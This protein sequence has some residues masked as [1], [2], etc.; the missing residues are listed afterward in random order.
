M[1]RSTVIV[2]GILTLSTA[3]LLLGARSG[4][5]PGDLAALFKS[6]AIT[7]AEGIVVRELRLPR[8]LAALIAGAA[9]GMAGALIQTLTR[10]PIA[11]P[12]LLGVNAGAA[13]GIVT[14]VWI[15]GPI[16]QPAM[17]LPA[18][19]G[20]LLSLLVVWTIGASSRSPLTLIL[21]GV[22]LTAFLSAILRGLILLDRHVLDVYRGWAVGVLDRVTF[23]ELQLGA[24]LFLLG[25]VLALVATR[26][27]DTLALGED[28]AITL[29]TNLLLGRLF[30]LGS[31]GVLATAAVIVAGPLVFVG[32][33]APHIARAIHADDTRSLTTV[34][35][36]L[37]AVLVLASDIVGRI[38]APGYVI[39]AGLW[40]SL[41]GGVFLI[42]AVRREGR[43]PA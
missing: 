1:I 5:T 21:A 26:R 25:C 17:V 10:N 33:V 31:I 32:L 22:A 35:G 24:P 18:L 39:E 20:A 3:S 2:A 34:S 27:L 40:I 16:S 7:D 15:A 14:T 29:G 28:L 30:T 11:D 13:L 8:T 37:G 23:V 36:C 43:N 38:I 9:L 4:V 6:P 19:A 42:V 12:G 41:I